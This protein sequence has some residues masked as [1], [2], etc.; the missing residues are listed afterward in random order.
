MNDFTLRIVTNHLTDG[1][2]T[3][4]VFGCNGLDSVKIYEAASE[5]DAQ[6]FEAALATTINQH[7][8]S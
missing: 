5:I 4:D 6:R 2:K 8:A 7:V 1:S 3:Y